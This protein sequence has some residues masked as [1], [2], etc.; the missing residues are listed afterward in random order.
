MKFFLEGRD[1]NNIARI[2][3]NLIIILVLLIF[4]V[5]KEKINENKEGFMNVKGIEKGNNKKRKKMIKI[6]LNS[7]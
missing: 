1:K 5:N 2:L 6:N 7:E 3:F 4:L